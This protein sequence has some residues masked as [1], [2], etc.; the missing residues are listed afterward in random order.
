MERKGEDSGRRHVKERKERKWKRGLGRKLNKKEKERKRTEKGK[1]K[2][3][4]GG[5]ETKGEGKKSGRKQIRNSYKFRKE[6]D[7]FRK[8]IWKGVEDRREK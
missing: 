2:R 3:M 6:K 8:S 5:Q 1:V 7:K 4:R